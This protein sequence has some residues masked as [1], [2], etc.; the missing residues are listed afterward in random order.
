[1]TWVDKGIPA[2]LI[3]Q[4]LRSSM[5]EAISANDSS[6]V[7]SFSNAMAMASCKEIKFFL[8]IKGFSLKLINRAFTRKSGPNRYFP[9]KP[10]ILSILLFAAIIAVGQNP[11]DIE[12]QLLV[13]WRQMHY[14]GTH[15][16]FEDS[17]I[18]RLDSLEKADTLF[19]QELAAAINSCP[20]CL[21]YDFPVLR[22]SGLVITTSADGKFRIYAWDNEA[23]GSMR[24]FEHVLQ[25]RSPAG[26]KATMLGG[27]SMDDEGGWFELIHP[28][29]TATVTYYLAFSRAIA[30]GVCRMET[31]RAFRIGSNGL[32]GP[33][34]LF[35]K[36]STLNDDIH[37]EFRDFDRR[38]TSGPMLHGL[39]YDSL[40]RTI[41]VPSLDEMEGAPTAPYTTYRWNGHYFFA[42]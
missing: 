12:R 30:C 6:R 5:N 41:K 32:I 40:R 24:Y 14:W 23:G 2:F 8:G 37:L 28:F 31:V 11:A 29:K 33:I 27:S 34:K 26:I 35:K 7:G 9:M 21:A 17:T 22:D 20:A 18:D 19:H 39:K 36:G 4:K 25:Y 15:F 42:K 16:S 1:M 10:T 13:P 3:G 38:R